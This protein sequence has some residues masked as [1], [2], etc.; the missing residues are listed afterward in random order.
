MG[1]TG[2]LGLLGVSGGLSVNVSVPTASLSNFSLRGIQFSFSGS[3]T[4]L[5]GVGVVLGAG[6]SYS[7]GGSSGT[8]RNVSGSITPVI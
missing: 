6:P 4:P 8:L 5:V 1:A 2:F 7:A 3:V